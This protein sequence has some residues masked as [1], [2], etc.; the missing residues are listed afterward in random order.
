MVHVV[1]VVLIAIGLLLHNREVTRL[2]AKHRAEQERLV[3][4]M[5]MAQRNEELALLEAEDLRHDLDEASAQVAWSPRN[6]LSA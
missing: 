4:A 5:C 1:Y 6:R 3:R 2:N